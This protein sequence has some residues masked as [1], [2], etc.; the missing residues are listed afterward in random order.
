[1][2]GGN[3]GEGGIGMRGRLYGNG[4][5]KFCGIFLMVGLLGLI[6]FGTNRK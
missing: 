6:G 3:K 4:E 2:E 5:N 1:M